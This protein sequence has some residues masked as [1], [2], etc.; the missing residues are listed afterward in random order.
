MDSDRFGLWVTFGLVGRG[1][2]A[3]FH[4]V[5][6]SLRGVVLVAKKNRPNAAGEIHAD[7]SIFGPVT[8]VVVPT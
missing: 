7:L 6:F 8:A 2:V 3:A 5:A 4:K 1:V